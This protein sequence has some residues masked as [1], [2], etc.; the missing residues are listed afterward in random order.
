MDLICNG[1]TMI[2]MVFLGKEIPRRADDKMAEVV[3]DGV[4]KASQLSIHITFFWL[5]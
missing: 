2:T 1:T 3:S 4:L 5:V